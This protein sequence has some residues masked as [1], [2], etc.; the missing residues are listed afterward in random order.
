MVRRFFGGF[1]VIAA[2]VAFVVLCGTGILLGL[3]TGAEE[4]MI[5]GVMGVP[6]P[7]RKRA[8]GV[9]NSHENM[10]PDR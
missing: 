1:T 3:F 7:L 9:E 8:A 4:A 6:N 5:A 2:T 10:S